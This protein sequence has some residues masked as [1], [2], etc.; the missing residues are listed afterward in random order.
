[1]LHWYHV[2]LAR[3]PLITQSIGSAILFGAGDVLAQQLVDKVGLEH[4]D[5]A[6][7]GRMTLYER[8][9]LRPRRHNLVQIHGAEHCPAQSQAY[10]HSPRL[11]RSAPLRSNTHV[12]L[13]LVHVHH[14][15]QRSVGE[16][17]NQLLVRLQ[18]QPDDLAVGAGGQ[19]HPGPAAASCAGGQSC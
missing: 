10:P 15:R 9:D 17:E 1:M 5:Y 13:P 12:S 16:V 7:T 3:R 4:H 8:C 6:R 2:Q 14:G 19:L 18:S 11:W